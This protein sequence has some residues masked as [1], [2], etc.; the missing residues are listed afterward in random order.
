MS[1]KMV[2]DDPNTLANIIVS[3]GGTPIP[4][5]TFTFDLPLSEVKTVIPKLNELGVAA[6][7]V[8]ERVTEAHPTQLRCN[9]TVMTLEL[10][11]APEKK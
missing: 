4:G 3:L 11:R 1:G 2:V 6:R 5:R 9:H 8:S 7:S 10:F